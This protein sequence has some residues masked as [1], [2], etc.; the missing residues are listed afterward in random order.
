MFFFCVTVCTGRQTD[1]AERLAK[2]YQHTRA[3]A[4]T[5]A[6][7]PQTPLSC[8]GDECDADSL[9]LLIHT[10]VQRH[11]SMHVFLFLLS[12]PDSWLPDA[13]SPSLLIQSYIPACIL[14]CL[15]YVYI[16]SFFVCLS[17][18]ALQL[19]A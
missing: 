3:C 18:Y 17:E 14:V 11:T 10:Y 4:H 12:M 19:V 9:S 7:I 6:K 1:T 2:E 8:G 16:C 5:H 13:D 15:V